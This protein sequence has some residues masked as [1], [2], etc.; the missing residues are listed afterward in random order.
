MLRLCR[1]P[2]VFTEGFAVTVTS[3]FSPF[4]PVT[5]KVALEPAEFAEACTGA[6]FAFA[7]VAFAAVSFAA[8]SFAAAFTAVSFAAVAFADAF[9]CAFAGA[10]GVAPPPG[11][12]VVFA[13]RGIEG[14]NPEDILLHHTYKTDPSR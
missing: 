4:S 10:S 11:S 3:N 8:V 13:F 9:A 12:A 2:P 1:F 7:A 5:V 14:G 6:A